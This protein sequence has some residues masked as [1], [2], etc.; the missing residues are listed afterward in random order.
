MSS[1]STSTMF[2]YVYVL[3]SVKDD[4]HYMGYANNLKRKIKKHNGGKNFQ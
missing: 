1:N 3:F 2:F 4:G